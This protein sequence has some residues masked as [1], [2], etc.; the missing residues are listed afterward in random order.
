MKW[1]DGC[2]VVLHKP[3]THLFAFGPLLALQKAAISPATQ[4]LG[5][6]GRLSI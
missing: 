4:A 1:A 2:E 3:S 5:E 6:V